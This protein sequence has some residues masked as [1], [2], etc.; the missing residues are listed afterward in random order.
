M[1]D[2]FAFKTSCSVCQIP[3][4][5][6]PST[7]RN[8]NGRFENIPLDELKYFFCNVIESEAHALLDYILYTDLRSELFAKAQAVYE[9]LSLTLRS[10]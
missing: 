9:E 10:A 3:L 5:R 8:G 4:R 6:S 2:D 1:Q 7:N